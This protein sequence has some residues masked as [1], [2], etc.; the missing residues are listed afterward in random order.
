MSRGR[1][2]V[3][4]ASRGIG[5]AIVR[6]LRERGAQ[7]LAVG[8]DA[9]AL[10]RLAHETGAWIAAVDLRAPGAP[11]RVVEVARD[12]LGGVD[13]LVQ[14]AGVIRYQGVGAID[15][16]AV[17]EQVG[18]N[19]VAPLMLAQALAPELRATR[20]AI[21]N[22]ASTLATRPAPLTAVYSATKAAML[23]WTRVFAV[24]L[25]PD[26]RVNA[27]APGVVDTAMVRQPRLAPGEPLPD[28]PERLVEAQ[29]EALRALHPLGRLGAPEDVAAAVVFLLDASWVTGA[30]LN[31]DG[32]LTAC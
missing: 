5:A 11:A 29:L 15:A 12:A 10:D 9:D 21:V 23:A 14:S 19:L 20:G 3:T 1:V 18:V 6:A 25:A 2:V 22:V 24:E 8:R 31:V 32:G 30:V 4:G 13:G 26:V 7:V 28:A 16:A 17:D 27:I